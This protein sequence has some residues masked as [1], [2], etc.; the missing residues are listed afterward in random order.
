MCKK[1]VQSQFKLEGETKAPSYSGVG[2]NLT[3]RA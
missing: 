1:N 2:S 3:D